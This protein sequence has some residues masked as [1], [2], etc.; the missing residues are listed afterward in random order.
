MYFDLLVEIGDL[1]LGVGRLGCFLI[2][3][4]TEYMRWL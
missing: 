3:P 4:P 1:P 2:L